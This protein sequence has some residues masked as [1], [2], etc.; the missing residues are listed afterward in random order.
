[1][2][3][4]GSRT[5][6]CFIVNDSN[7]QALACVYFED[8]PGRRTAGFKNANDTRGNHPG[9]AIQLIAGAS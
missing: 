4:S 2:P 1:M 6:A 7:G 3:T 5:D 8:E 9:D